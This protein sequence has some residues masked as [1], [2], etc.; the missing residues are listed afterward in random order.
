M[1]TQPATTLP[2]HTYNYLA[3]ALLDELGINDPSQA[4]IDKTEWLVAHAM[5]GNALP[6][7]WLSRCVSRDNFAQQLLQRAAA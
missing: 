2:K 7:R 1:N 5:R 4:Q 6:A 3:I